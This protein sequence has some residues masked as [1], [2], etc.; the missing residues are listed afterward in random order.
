MWISERFRPLYDLLN[1]DPDSIDIT[2]H[3]T[4][5]NV[6]RVAL[7]DAQAFVDAGKYSNAVDRVHTAFHGYMHEVLES[8]QIG[9][10]RSDSLPALL[11][12]LYEFYGQ[13]IRPT[14]VASR[15]K[16]TLRSS[17]GIVQSINEIRNNNT[18][19]H[20]NSQLIDRHEAELVIRVVTTSGPNSGTKTSYYSASSS[21]AGG[22]ARR[23]GTSSTV[24]TCSRPCG[25]LMGTSSRTSR[26]RTGS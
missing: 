3:E 24:P 19:A 25:F 2:D 4:G 1:E 9:F 23:H 26:R 13:T 16:G 15:I 22:R 17:G 18:I 6:V 21:T 12:K 10:E 8:H 5:S 7:K 20:P 14:G 11:T